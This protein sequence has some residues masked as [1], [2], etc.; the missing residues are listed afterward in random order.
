MRIFLLVVIPLLSLTH[1][2]ETVE[3]VIA[4]VSEHSQRN[5]EGDIAVLK[6][7]NLLAAWSEFYGGSRDDSAGRIAAKI[8]NDGGRTW[9]GKRTLVENTGA[10]NVMSVSFLRLHTGELLLFYLE[11]NSKS[12]LDVM[13]RRSS[14]EGTTWSNPVRVTEDDGYWV[15]NN[16]RVIQL[17]GGRIVCPVAMTEKVWVKGHVFRT[18]CFYSDDDGKTWR[19]GAGGISAPKRG[20]MEPGLIEKRDGSVLQYIRTQTGRQWFA[21][22]D[23]LT[24]TWSKAAP[25]KLISPE[26]PATVVKLPGKRGWAAFHN[27]NID[28]SNSHLG[29]RTPLVVRTSLDEGKTWSKP[30]SIESDPEKT[31]SYLSAD[32][33]E[34]RALLT[35]YESDEKNRISWKFKSLPLE[36]FPSAPA[37]QRLDRYNL[38]EFRKPDGT[39]GTVS[40]IEGWKSRRSEIISGMEKVTG[41]FPGEKKRVELDGRVI[42]EADCGKYIRKLIH[43]Q[44]EPGSVTPA[45]LCI[46]KT[47]VENPAPAVLCLHPTD[48]RIGHNVVVG[49]GGKK[50]RQYASELA[51]RGF[52]TISPSYPHLAGYHPNLEALGYVSGTM[53]AIWDNSRAVDYLE[54]LDF[55]DMSKGVGAVGH[56]LGGHNAIYTAVFDSRISVV[57]S[58]CGFDSFIDYYDAA[59]RV[60]FYRKGWCQNR[61]MPRMSDYRGRLEQIPFD[62]PELLGA[63]APRPVFVNA[64]ENDSNFRRES[65]ARCIAAAAPVYRLFGGE[66]R[67]EVEYPDCAHDFPEEMREKAYALLEKTLY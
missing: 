38:L 24:D 54:E 35:Y 6:N 26:A 15:M 29:K 23:D 56:S 16:A 36:W 44:S 33:Y 19:R 63:L 41:S 60:W 59:E 48:N 45:W 66:N 3:V 65:V 28:E 61:Y 21:E 57:V 7:G 39:S 40:D 34:G 47:A 11:K 51:E 30:K 27:P 42:E 4:P 31:Y 55:V 1:A 17:S 50:N 14:D 43:Y 52:V 12:D 8:S 2:E 5:S 22:S 37:L 25:W 67:I 53:K 62:F 18:V 13:V 46:P 20:A 10:E 64:P 58:S 49:L 32:F 9:A